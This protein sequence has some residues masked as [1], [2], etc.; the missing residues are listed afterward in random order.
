MI[1][2]CVERRQH[3]R[4]TPSTLSLLI[5]GC[6]LSW[7]NACLYGASFSSC[8]TLLSISLIP[9]HLSIVKRTSQATLMAPRKPLAKI[10]PV[11]RR[12]RITRSSGCKLTSQFPRLASSNA[13]LTPLPSQKAKRRKRK[14]KNKRSLYNSNKNEPLLTLLFFAIFYL[15]QLSRIGGKFVSRK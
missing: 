9:H 5:V 3:S 11:P 14:R 13:S 15:S 8:D 4:L 6:T 10:S 1:A 7:S 12:V 2:W